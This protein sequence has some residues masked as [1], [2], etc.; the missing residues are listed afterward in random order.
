[1]RTHIAQEATSGVRE[2]K[3]IWEN[4]YNLG[5]RFG[6]EEPSGNFVFPKHSKEVHKAIQ[7][8]KVLQRKYEKDLKKCKEALNFDGRDDAIDTLRWRTVEIESEA[9]DF[10]LMEGFVGNKIAVQTLFNGLGFPRKIRTLI[11]DHEKLLVEYERLHDRNLAEFLEVKAQLIDRANRGI[12][13]LSGEDGTDIDLIEEL[14]FVGPD[15][16]VSDISTPVS[17]HDDLTREEC[18]ICLEKLSGLRPVVRLLCGHLTHGDNCLA[19]WVNSM[20]VSS[21]TCPVCRRQIMP[22]RPLRPVIDFVN[23][24]NEVDDNLWSVT[25]DLKVLYRDIAELTMT[26]DD[27]LVED[28]PATL[29][30]KPPDSPSDST[31]WDIFFRDNNKAGKDAGARDNA[32]PDNAAHDANQGNADRPDEPYR[33]RTGFHYG[34]GPQ[35]LGIDVQVEVK[36]K[37]FRP[38]PNLYNRLYRLFTG[39]DPE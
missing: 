15:T 36:L 3:Q 6:R 35:D 5:E 28:K 23:H 27:A 31:G 7:A 2:E 25:E 22:R 32:A 8:A 4:L 14:E 10:R 9:A 13:R 39:R 24:F 33:M 21:N 30:E 20:V 38:F 16:K 18:P 1:M 11:R 19:K 17:R 26:F 34:Y 29:D 37:P 12:L